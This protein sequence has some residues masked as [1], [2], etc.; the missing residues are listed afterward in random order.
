[1]YIKLTVK[2]KYYKYKITIDMSKKA[3]ALSLNTI[4][5]AI[6]V[7]VVL[8]VL[9]MIFTGYFGTRFTPEVTS[10]SNAGGTCKTE[11]GLDAFGNEVPQLNAQCPVQ[12]DV[13]C[14][15]GLGVSLEEETCGPLGQVCREGEKCFDGVCKVPCADECLVTDACPDTH[16]SADGACNS[17]QVCCKAR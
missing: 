16:D 4:I 8:V 11:C 15:K 17:G 2:F 13:C 3:Q 12:G 9:I 7:L 10:C 1:M 6:V 14:S 5:V